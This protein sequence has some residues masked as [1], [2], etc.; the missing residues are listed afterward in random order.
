VSAAV[1]A[2]RDRDADAPRRD[3]TLSIDAGRTSNSPASPDAQTAKAAR[4]AGADARTS[5]DARAGPFR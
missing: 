5:A 1:T 3:F 2:S 4:L